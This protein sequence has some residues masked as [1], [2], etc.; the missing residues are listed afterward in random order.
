MVRYFLSEAFD[1]ESPTAQKLVKRAFELLRIDY[2]ELLADGLQILR[3]NQKEAYIG[4]TRFNVLAHT[5]WFPLG[6]DPS[7][8]FNPANGGA[9]R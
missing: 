4:R 2:D 6:T 7:H 8:D 5:D 1:S 3:Y 9:N